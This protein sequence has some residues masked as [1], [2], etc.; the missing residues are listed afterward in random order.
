MNN[1]NTSIT[2]NIIE[3]DFTPLKNILTLH[4]QIM[5]MHERRKPLLN[6]LKLL[7]YTDTS[8]YYSIED[9]ENIEKLEEEIDFIDK[10]SKTLMDQC[11][12]IMNEHNVTNI[13]LLKL[14]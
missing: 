4:S 9:C 12:V 1:I 14:E 6:K 5:N 11:V 8:N 13:P 3:N 7:T 2:S 10:Y